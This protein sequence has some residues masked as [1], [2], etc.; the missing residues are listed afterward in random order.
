MGLNLADVVVL[1]NLG[2]VAH[3][4]FLV[5]IVLTI[6]TSAKIDKE[7]KTKRVVCSLTSL[8]AASS[9]LTD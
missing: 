1:C 3:S 4:S 2:L 8:V 7:I 5:K 6:P 9:T